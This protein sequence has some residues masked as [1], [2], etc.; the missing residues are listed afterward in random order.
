MNIPLIKPDL[1]HLED[2]REP[3]EEILA[4]GRITNFGKHMTQFE[5]E[6]SWPHWVS[7][8]GRR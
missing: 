7:S 8:A 5:A 6:T 2:I 4:S 3:L 1:P